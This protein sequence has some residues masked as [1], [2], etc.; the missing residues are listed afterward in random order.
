[1]QLPEALGEI[2]HIFCD[3]TGTLTLNDLD[4]NSISV[5]GVV[6]HGDTR[7]QI[8]SMIEEQCNRRDAEHLFQCFCLCAEMRVIY[9]SKT[10]Q[11]SYDGESQDELRLLQLAQAGSIYEL[12]KRDQF[13]ITLLDKSTGQSAIFPI[14]RVIA[15]TVERK[16]MSI[17]VK[18]PFDGNRLY[19]YSKGADEAIFKVLRKSEE[20]SETAIQ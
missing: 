2:D 5:S 9:N 8:N 16:K 15:F 20:E 3:K 1:M 19:V 12:A 14:V 11:N 4:V 17:V 7:E 18:N 13:K 6:C 10:G